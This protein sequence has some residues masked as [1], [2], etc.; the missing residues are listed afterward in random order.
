MFVFF[1]CKKVE[2]GVVDIVC[3]GYWCCLGE[4]GVWFKYFLK[5]MKVM[6]CY[7]NMLVDWSVSVMNCCC[8]IGF[9]IYMVSL[10]LLG[11][12]KWKCCLLGKVKILWVRMLFVVMMLLCVFLR[13]L[14]WIMVSGVVMV[15][16]LAVLKL[17]LILLV[18]VVV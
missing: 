12:W 11:L 6:Y 5:V 3:W 8:Y 16:F 4:D 10:L 9:V 7:L 1:V 2:K 13:L 14:I 15:W 17:I 18:V